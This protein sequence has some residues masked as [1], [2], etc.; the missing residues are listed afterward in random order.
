MKKEINKLPG[1][2]MPYFSMTKPK[3]WKA[4]AVWYDFF[5]ARVSKTRWTI[6]PSSS[7]HSDQ[8]SG[9][10]GGYNTNA[11]RA[12]H[13]LANL[14]FWKPKDA[15]AFVAWFNEEQE[16]SESKQHIE[17]AMKVLEEAGYI[18]KEKS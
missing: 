11:K 5:V 16:R 10:V 13:A 2:Q 14:G 3:V 8:V 7:S 15:D 17:A 6:I 12:A 18:V 9:C 4:V 1:K